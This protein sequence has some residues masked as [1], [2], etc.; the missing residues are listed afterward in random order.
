MSEN[1]TERRWRFGVNR[2]ILLALIVGGVII[3]GQYPPAR[4]AILL[5]AEPVWGTAYDPLFYFPIVDTPFFITNTL[6]AMVLA[7]I[8]LLLLLVFVVVPHVRRGVQAA[9]RGMAN[10]VEGFLEI[11]YN[12]TESTAGKWTRKIFPWFATITMLVLVMNWMELIPGV[13]SIGNFDM[14]HY[15]DKYIADYAAENDMMVAD[16]SSEKLHHLEEEAEHHYWEKCADANGPDN[17]TVLVYTT[18][19]E[20]TGICAKPVVPWVRAVATDLNFTIGLALVSVVMIQVVGVQAQGLSYFEKFINVRTLF[21][22]PFFGAIDFAVGLFEIVSEFSKIISFSFRLFGNIFAGA[23][24][25]FVI[26]ALIPVGAQSAVLIL[27]FFV[28]MIQAIVFGMLTMVF[29]SQATHS[30]HGDGEED[31]H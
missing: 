25:L 26:G 30:H 28:G 19:S 16:I 31:H 17:S 4:P 27:E 3:T 15:Q 20:G 7:D 21:T 24:L 23:V 8:V 29:M 9:P 22:K 13:D 14:H 1:T 18:S 11:L 12:L 2:W 10:F 6:V 5:N